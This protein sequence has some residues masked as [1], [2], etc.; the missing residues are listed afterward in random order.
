MS[1]P[2]RSAYRVMCCVFG[3]KMAR[4]SHNGP[5]EFYLN[6]K[7]ERNWLFHNNPSAVMSAWV[8][9]DGVRFRGVL[10]RLKPEGVE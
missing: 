6:A 1:Y 2:A 9:R 3:D 10:A 8:E 4:A 7:D 5:Y